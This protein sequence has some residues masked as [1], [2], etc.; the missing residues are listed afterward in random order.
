MKE[1]VQKLREETGAGIMDCKRALEEADG[2]FEK[3]KAI[4]REKGFAKA[5]KKSERKTGAGHLES[6]VHAGRVGVLLE[7]RCE[8]DFVARNE[9]FRKLA[10]ELAMQIAAMNPENV[11]ELMEQPFVKDEKET[12]KNLVRQTIAELGE[13]IEVARFARYEI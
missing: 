7:L 13:N 2:N 3:A 9:K 12:I 5:A 11:N 4:I 1:Q 10:H 6:Y 8:T